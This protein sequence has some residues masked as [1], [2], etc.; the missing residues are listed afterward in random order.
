MLFVVV[1]WYFIEKNMADTQNN[2]KNFYKSLFTT[3][4]QITH[5]GFVGISGLYYSNYDDEFVKIALEKYKSLMINYA[6]P[7]SL[8]VFPSCITR[9][10]LNLEDY[11]D[12]NL[13][14]LTAAMASSNIEELYISSHAAVYCNQ[15]YCRLENL[16]PQIK[17][18]SIQSGRDD[19]PL[20][21]LHHGIVSVCIHTRYLS[22]SSF[23]NLPSSVVDLEIHIGDICDFST[24]NIPSS[25]RN[26]T[27][28]SFNASNFN[29][30]ILKERF[31]HMNITLVS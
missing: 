6:L 9:L 24:L 8:L 17:K 3:K 10:C 15:F 25:V 26:L 16:P 23:E 21:G 30:T 4:M 29:M 18:I 13:A 11:N 5:N 14:E 19:I 7:S 31:P 1:R 27:I 12:F 28:S 22:N 2:G 20:D